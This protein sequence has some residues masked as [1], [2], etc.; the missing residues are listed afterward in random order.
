[1]KASEQTRI[2]VIRNN[3]LVPLLPCL[4]PHASKD[5]PWRG[6]LL[7]RHNIPSMELPE[8][9]HRELCLHLQLRG[10]DQ[11]QWWSE[12]RHGIV[13][14]FPGSI[15][16]VPPG[17]R[18][19]T[20][21]QGPSERLIVSL[22]PQ[23]L[24]EVTTNAGAKLPEFKSTWSVNDPALQRILAQMGREQSEGW[25]LGRLYADLLAENLASTLLRRHAFNP[26]DPRETRGGLPMPQLRRAMEFMTANMD[27]DLHLEEIAREAGLSPF[28]FSREF[29]AVTGQTPYQYLL[30]QRMDRAKRLLK[31]QS[32]P[33]Q[34]IAT[35][36]GFR[37]PVNFIRTFRQRVGVTPGT[38]RNQS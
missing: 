36:T 3:E 24:E 28:H 10:D 6:V 15:M 2:S 13:K 14:T 27:I 22:K 17:T 20:L 38:W 35:M 12:G 8:H 32:W 25:P 37:S 18:D 5:Q 19:R 9:E 16:V 33:V 29:R 26:V 23:F 11:M 31:E 4:A 1:V 30:S 34:E 7:E 21:W